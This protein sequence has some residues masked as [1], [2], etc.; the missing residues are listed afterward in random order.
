MFSSERKLIAFISVFCIFLALL[1]YTWKQRTSIP[2]VSTTFENVMTPFAYGVAR[3]LANV[4]TGIEVID[5]AI[6]HYV[7]EETLANEKAALAQKEVNYDEVVAENMRLRQLLQFKSSHPRLAVTAAHVMTRDFGSWTNTFT[8]DQGSE[9]GIEVNMAVVVPS[10]VVGFVS[11]VYSH[12]ARVQTMLDPRTSIGVIVQRP[13]SR[14]ASILKGNGNTKE[15]PIMVNIPKDGDVLTGDTL[16]TSGY[17]G[18][19]PKGLIVGHILKI[20]SDEEGFV[21]NVVV[22]PS[23]NFNTIEEVFVIRASYEGAPDKPVLEPKLVPQTQ[24]DQV[25]GVK[26][27]I[28]R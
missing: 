4:K 15:M 2:F 8:I 5:R 25:E 11:D 1:G 23:A 9:E 22:Q 16:I 7:D 20:T 14:V 12:S 21:K 26:G 24:R 6:G 28:T 10:G 17:G 18:V 27:A 19:Y 13:E 3:S